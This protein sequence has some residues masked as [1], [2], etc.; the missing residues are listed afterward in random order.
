MINKEHWKNAT[1][2][3]VDRWDTPEVQNRHPQAFLPFATGGRSCIGFAFA[4]QEVNYIVARL[5]LNFRF[6]NVTGE[7]VVYDPGFSLYRPLN[8][9]VK[10]LPQEDA[11]K[12][13]EEAKSEPKKEQQ[14]K[15]APKEGKNAKAAA[16]GRPDLPVVYALH[17]SNSGTAKGYAS[18]L[19]SKARSLGFRTEF[20]TLNDFPIANEEDIAKLA[21]GHN[22][23]LVV[24]A[25]YNGEP[26]DSALDFD[27]AL[28]GALEA[29]QEAK[30]R[31]HGLNYSVFGCGNTQWGATYQAFPNKVDAS[32]KKLGAEQFHPKGTGNSD[33]DQD[34]DWHEWAQSLWGTL[35]A[36][37]GIDLNNPSLGADAEAARP[38]GPPLKVQFQPYH[39]TEEQPIRPPLEGLQQSQIVANVELVDEDTPLPRG[40]RLITLS[41]PQGQTYRAG[42]HVEIVPENTDEAVEAVLASLNLVEQGTFSVQV[43]DEASLNTNSLA[44][45]LAEVGT[46]TVKEALRYWADLSAPVSR[47]ALQLIASRMDEDDAVRK[48]LEALADPGA[49]KDAAA[50]FNRKNRNFATFLEHYPSI[51]RVMGLPELLLAVKAI[52]ARRYSIAS[53]PLADAKTLKI[54]VGVDVVLRGSNEPFEGLCS[55]YLKRREPGQHV[56]LKTRPAPEAFHL[57][58]DH[59]IPVTMVA[60]GTGIAPFLGFFEE[61]KARDYKLKKSGGKAEKFKLY[62]GTTHHDMKNL[63]E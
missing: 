52:S 62:Y 44:A 37:Y 16:V 31:L 30:D 33:D 48:E 45:K 14:E 1:V 60:A 61:R 51:A 46:V 42:D 54:C 58:E 5:V 36:Q 55:G 25:T 39:G 38:S 40:M 28:D 19:V 10:A 4:L 22:V 7:P 29:G 8:L 57:P 2:F 17:A 63:R 6:E 23:V 41:L 3:D 20:M 56:W 18:E 21:S 12:V 49:S 34:R 32:L 24:A 9:K 11:D 15:A 27:I 50:E 13:L 53:S 43:D 47:G 59:S 35:A 26:S